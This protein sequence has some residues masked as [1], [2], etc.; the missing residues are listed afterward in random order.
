MDFAFVGAPLAAP[1]RR[2]RSKIAAPHNRGLPKTPTSRLFSATSSAA[3]A[4]LSRIPNAD[5][6]KHLRKLRQAQFLRPRIPR[7]PAFLQSRL[8]PRRIRNPP[9]IIPQ[10][11]PLLPKASLHE[12]QKPPLIRNPQ[13]RALAGQRHP[14]Q[15]R[16]NLRRRPKR[17]RRNPQLNLRPRIKLAQSRKIT[18]SPPPRPRHNPLRN[19]Q[20]NHNVNGSNA[21]GHSKQM[22]QNRRSNVVRQIPINASP[23]SNQDRQIDLQHISHNNFHPPPSPRFLPQPLRQP[24]IRLN[25]H[26]PRPSP[27]QQFRHLAMPRPNFKPALAC[28]HAQAS[29]DIFFRQPKSPRKCCPSFC[30]DIAP[31]SLAISPQSN[32]RVLLDEPPSLR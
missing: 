23:L 7:N 30:R 11:L 5:R 8:N 2:P 3:E 20:L 29:A 12:L 9:Q 24:R 13:P 10:R 26:H 22:P 17:P 14:H 25:R 32:C 4:R 19:F 18:V 28:R 15:R 31:P 1:V 6:L 16:R 27:R 21:I